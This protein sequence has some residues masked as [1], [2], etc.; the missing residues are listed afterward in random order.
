MKFTSMKA[1]HALA[2]GL[3][4]TVALA[5]SAAAQIPQQATFG[6]TAITNAT[7]HTVTNGVI[8]GGTVLLDGHRITAVGRGISVPS[9]YTVIDAS[10]KHVYPGF[11][12]SG[13][14]LG[15][16]EI[17]AVPVTVDDAEVGNFNPQMRAFT[18]INP[19]SAAIAVTR[20]S[21]VTNVIAHP[22][23]GVVSGKATLIDLFGYSPDSMA[24]RADAALHIEWPTQARRGWGDNR[25]DEDRRKAYERGL[26]QLQDYWDNAR[27]YH[28]MWVAFEA[29]PAG[30]RRPDRNPEMQGMRDVFAGKL[31]VMVS[32]DR[33]N[34]IRSAL[35]W[36]GRQP[37]AVEFVL[38]SAAEG[39]RVADEIAAAGIPVLVGPVLRTP[40][41]AYDDF[42][43]PYENAGLLAKAGV[44]VAIRTGQ[45]E[46]VRN[47]PY[48]AGYAAV[49]GLGR[50]EALRAITITP[51]R[52][53]GVED[54]L[55]SI[56]TGKRA[57]L[58]ISDGDPFEPAT[59]IEAVFINGY[60][61]PMMSRQTMLYDEF[62]RRT[63]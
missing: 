31:P 20:V 38:S 63:P 54:E 10:G 24:V 60:N 23:S 15:L 50:E 56:E 33:E 36:I 44:V 12:D 52:I 9:G 8:E 13:T 18:A 14:R 22:T 59:Q 47:L 6:P 26:A 49:Y 17:S 48:N 55:G 42:R 32:V 58:F 21:G 37:D 29:D 53:F 4:L 30:K 39:W 2:T 40:V 34:D 46:N 41:R 62:L 43:R 61:I 57:N 19:N 7:I 51:A 16:I 28:D 11:I 25:S 3:A 5:T 45:T 27:A 35:E 1:L